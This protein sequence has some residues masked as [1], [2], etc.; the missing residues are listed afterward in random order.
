ALPSTCAMPN[1]H[2]HSFP[3]RRSS[4]LPKPLIG[5]SPDAKPKAL[6]PAMRPEFRAPAKCAK[7]KP[8]SQRAAA[9]L[10]YGMARDSNVLLHAGRSEEHTSELQSRVDIVCRLLLA[11]K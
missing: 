8:L 9:R 3:T 11:K 4:D 10:K 5:P 2:L 6:L 1:A 7:V